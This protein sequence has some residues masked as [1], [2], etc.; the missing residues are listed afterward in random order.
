MRVRIFSGHE[1]RISEGEVYTQENLQLFCNGAAAGRQQLSG[2]CSMFP[3][4]EAIAWRREWRLTLP[5]PK[6]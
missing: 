3:G 4:L 6:N 2:Q 1:R 5:E